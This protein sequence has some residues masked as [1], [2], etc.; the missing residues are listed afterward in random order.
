MPHWIDSGWNA[1]R[2]IQMSNVILHVNFQ[3]NSFR[4]SFS[5]ASP[6]LWQNSA[7]Q[8]VSGRKYLV[9]KAG[10]QKELTYFFFLKT[11]CIKIKDKRAHLRKKNVLVIPAIFIRQFASKP[12]ITFHI[13][14]LRDHRLNSELSKLPMFVGTVSLPSLYN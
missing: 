10:A 13:Q 3:K 9:G 8:V 11:H 14:Q 4:I 5:S 12:Q 7:S 1:R 6:L 2:T